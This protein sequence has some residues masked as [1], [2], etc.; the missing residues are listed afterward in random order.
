[1]ELQ[2]IIYLFGISSHLFIF[3]FARHLLDE[4]SSWLLLLKI[5]LGLAILGVLL[6]ILFY[7][8]RNMYIA[9]IAP[10]YSVLIYRPMYLYFVHKTKRK[11]I[12]T[13]M[14]WRSGLFFD[15]LFNVVYAILSTVLPMVGILVLSSMINKLLQVN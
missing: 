11:P 8:E 13:T 5:A 7:K 3:L 6:S 1:M 4:K 2:T 10:L 14:D 9:L 15:R 12:D